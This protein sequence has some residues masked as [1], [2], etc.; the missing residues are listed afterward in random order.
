MEARKSTS[1]KGRIVRSIGRRGTQSSRKISEFSFSLTK[2]LLI[3]T[4]FYLFHKNSR[5]I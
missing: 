1:R 4:S 2:F 5:F 3:L